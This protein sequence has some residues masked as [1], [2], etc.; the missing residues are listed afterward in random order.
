M[1]A[2]RDLD[3]LTVGSLQIYRDPF[4]VLVRHADDPDGPC[5]R[6]EP[7]AWDTFLDWAKRGLYNLPPPAA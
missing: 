5:V 1:T 2:N 3:W 7:A 6:F 4:D